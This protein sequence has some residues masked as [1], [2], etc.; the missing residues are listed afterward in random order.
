MVALAL[1]FRVIVVPLMALTVA[2]RR[3]DPIVSVPG[4]LATLTTLLPVELL[5]TD[6]EPVVEVE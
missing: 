5:V 1:A 3:V 6:T 4:T 2:P